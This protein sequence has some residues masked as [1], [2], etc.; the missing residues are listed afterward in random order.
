VIDGLFA[1]GVCTSGW[2]GEVYGNGTC[3]AAAL[4]AGRTAAKYICRNLL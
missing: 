4:Y 1:A 2:D 3:Q